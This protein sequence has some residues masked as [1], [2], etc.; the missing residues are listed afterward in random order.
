[1]T[2]GAGVHQIAGAQVQ[3]PGDDSQKRDE[4]WCWEEGPCGP[5]TRCSKQLKD[6]RGFLWPL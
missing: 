4:C 3:R 5:K 1:M 2:T 6:W